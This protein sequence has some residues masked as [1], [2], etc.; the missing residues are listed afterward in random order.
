MQARPTSPALTP[1][2]MIDAA[3]RRAGETW[4]VLT[5]LTVEAPTWVRKDKRGGVGA[6]AATQENLH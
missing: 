1:V 2:A 4:R 6:I 3:K 5:L